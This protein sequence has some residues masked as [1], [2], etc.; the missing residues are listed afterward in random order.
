MG[1]V[2]VEAAVLTLVSMAGLGVDGG[3][4]AVPGHAPHD[5]EDAVG[6]DS[7]VLA[8]H[9]GQQRS[10]LG[11]LAVQLV[12]VEHGEG[13]VGVAHQSVDQGVSSGGVVPVT[14]GLAQGGV[15]VVAAQ[16]GA[17][18]ASQLRS[19]G[20]QH[21]ADGGAQLGDGVLGGHRVVEGGG[22]EHPG[23]VLEHSRLPGGHQR[24]FVQAVLPIRF[25]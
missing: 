15:I 10:R 2:A 22:V 13:G 11:C 14:G 8:G 23:P 4:D 7:H 21:L 18:L 6:A 17:D 25:P 19:Q 24:V 12:A 20:G 1:L 9:K 16:H 3:D 5:A